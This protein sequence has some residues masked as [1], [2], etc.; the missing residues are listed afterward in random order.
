M[1]FVGCSFLRGGRL[2]L[3]LQWGV[4]AAATDK[5]TF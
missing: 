5:F 4:M 3:E 1:P 2:P